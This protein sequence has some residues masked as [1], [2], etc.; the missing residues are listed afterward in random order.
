M[1][2]TIPLLGFF[3]NSFRTKA[4]VDSTG[5][6]G[7]LRPPAR[8]TLSN[9]HAVLF[10][11]GGLMLPLVN[12]LAITIPATIIPIFLASMAAYA[13]AWMRFRGSDFIFFTIFA[14]QVVPLQMALVPLQKF[15]N[16]GAHIGSVTRSSRTSASRAAWPRSGCRTRCSRCRSR[17]SCCTTSSR[18]CRSR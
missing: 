4:D 10:G 7:L 1:L 5:L 16:G 3:L 9:Y 2:W 15:Y 18:S 12:S 14:L 6:V 13:L 8:C 17:C 11:D